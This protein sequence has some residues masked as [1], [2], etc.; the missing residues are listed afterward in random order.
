MRHFSKLLVLSLILI[1]NQAIAAESSSKSTTPPPVAIPTTTNTSPLANMQQLRKEGYLDAAKSLGLNYVKDHP[2]DGDV[3][4]LIG[5]LEYQQGNYGDATFYLNEVLAQTPTYMDA[6]IGLIRTK[7]AE[8]KYNEGLALIAEGFRQS[9]EN[10]DLVKLQTEINNINNSQNNVNPVQTAPLPP[11][12][13]REIQQYRSKGNLKAALAL[14]A[15][16]LETHPDDVDIRLQIGLIANQQKDYPKAELYLSQVLQKTPAYVDA[17]IGLIHTKLAIGDKQAAKE[18]LAEGLKLSPGNQQLLKL[19]K[20]LS[21][22][23]V[24]AVPLH[25]TVYKPAP[26]AVPKNLSYLEKRADII[27][28]LSVNNDVWHNNNNADLWAQKGKIEFNMRWYPQAAYSAKKALQLDPNNKTAQDILSS[29]NEMNPYH[30]HGVNEIGLGS[31]NAY[32][33]DLQTIWDYSGLYYSRDTDIGLIKGKVNY[34][35]RLHKQAPQYELFYQPRLNKN[36]YFD[37]SAA[38]SD[39]PSLFPTYFAGAEGYINFENFFELSAGGRHSEIDAT[40]NTTYFNTYTASISH[41]FEKYWLSF[42]AYEFTPK[43]H[44]NS[45]LYTGTLRRYFA[46]N[47]HFLSLTAGTGRSPDLS[48]LITVNFIVIKNNFVNLNYEFPVFNHSLILNVGGGYTRWVYPSDLVRELYTASL[49]IK[50]RF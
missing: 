19:K 24:K 47:D 18:L 34:A 45:I 42:R 6:R 10:A 29:I 32:V 35:S 36:I 30:A 23:S 3:L 28:L 5:L 44:D 26:T 49:G 31:D 38:Y 27:S 50:H 11:T 43:T 37:I 15:K 12:H 9:P 7:I 20:N 8:K 39:E 17:R 22:D 46:T 1:Q 4:L 40:F 48:D 16:D 25:K 14:A 2:K 21:G 33:S 41:Y 13:L